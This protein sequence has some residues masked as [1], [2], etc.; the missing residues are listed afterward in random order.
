MLK[1]PRDALESFF[2]KVA[3]VVGGDN[4][5]DVCGQPTTTRAEIQCLR[6]EMHVDA[7][8]RQLGDL[9]PVG[10]V[11][12]RA[13]DFVHDDACCAASAQFPEHGI[14][15]RPAALGGRLLLLKPLADGDAVAFGERHN[16]VLLRVE[17]HTVT[18]LGGG[19]ANVSKTS[20]HRLSGVYSESTKSSERVESSHGHEPRRSKLS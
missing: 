19:D 5:L 3:D 14:E 12:R 13:V 18:L 8:I 6:G 17:R 16:G 11:A 4:G 7:T 2:A 20:L 15:H 10:E 1:A 9:G